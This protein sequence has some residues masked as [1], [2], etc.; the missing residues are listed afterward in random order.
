MNYLWI[1]LIQIVFGLLILAT[2]LNMFAALLISP[3]LKFTEIIH[4]K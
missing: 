2:V 4:G 3:I 1:T